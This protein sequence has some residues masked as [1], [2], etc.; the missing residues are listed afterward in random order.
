MVAGIGCRAGVSGEQVL[1]AIEAAIAT[2]R[3]TQATQH[4]TLMAIATAASK[5]SEPGIRA[6]ATVRGLPLLAIAQTE[7]EAANAA[8]VTRSA[9]SIA[10]MNVESVA[11]AAALAGAAAVARGA[12]DATATATGM[13]GADGAAALAATNAASAPTPRLLLP[14]IAVGPVTCAL[15]SVTP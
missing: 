6:A 12:P 15:A 5:A 1:A 10:A 7:L 8:T 11:E 14:R 2:L 9:R 3:A 13:T 4:G